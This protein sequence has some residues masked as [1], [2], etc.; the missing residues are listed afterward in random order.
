MHQKANLFSNHIYLCVYLCVCAHTH[1]PC[2]WRSEANWGTHSWWQA[3]LLTKPSPQPFKYQ[4]SKM[5]THLVIL[6]R[7]KI[8]L[9]LSTVISRLSFTSLSYLSCLA[10]S[11]CWNARTHSDDHERSFLTHSW[12]NTEGTCQCG[13]SQHCSRLPPRR[14]NKQNTEAM[15]VTL[16]TK[17]LS[18]PL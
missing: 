9:L 15:T 13:R 18:V 1:V 5:F 10:S 2:V 8:V 17:T 6:W 14:L 3:P 7:R 12:S 16:R 11:S 4:I